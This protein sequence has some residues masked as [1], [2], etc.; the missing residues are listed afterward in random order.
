MS[1]SKD[2]V[3]K[4]QTLHKIKHGFEI[5]YSV[6]ETQLQVL[7]AMIRLTASSKEAE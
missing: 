4:F 5:N 1:L 3:R 6:A 2:L 7:A